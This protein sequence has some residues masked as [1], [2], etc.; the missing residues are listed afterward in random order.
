MKDNGE[1]NILVRKERSKYLGFWD[2]LENWFILWIIIIITM[3]NFYCYFKYEH[4]F[5]NF[6]MVFIYGTLGLIELYRVCYN[7]RLRE[8]ELK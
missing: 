7:N 8:K 2:N 3:A 1:R 4:H 6:M 5:F